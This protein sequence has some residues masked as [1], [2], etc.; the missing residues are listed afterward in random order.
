MRFKPSARKLSVSL[1]SY[2]VMAEQQA[3]PHTTQI[4]SIP[5]QSS[6]AAY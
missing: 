2:M 5:T 3:Q 4:Y 6:Q 1:E